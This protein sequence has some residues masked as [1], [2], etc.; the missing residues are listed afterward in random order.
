[1]TTSKK[2][3]KSALQEIDFSPVRELAQNVLSEVS[4]VI[5]GYGDIL[6]NLF[7]ALLTNG[8]VLL[9]GVPGLGKTVMAKTFAKN[10][11]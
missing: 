11:F 4:S 3:S 9:E 8:H 10:N 2:A 6:Q 1:M 5:V 7:I